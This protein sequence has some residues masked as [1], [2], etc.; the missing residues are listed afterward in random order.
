MEENLKPAP[1]EPL[2]LK[3]VNSYWLTAAILAVLLV[4]ASTVGSSWPRLSIEL[5]EQVSLA[6]YGASIAGSYLSWIGIAIA[7]NYYHRKL[8]MFCRYQPFWWLIHGLLS[9]SIGAL[10]LLWDTYLLWIALGQNFSLQLAY[11]EKILRWLPFEILA[12]WACLGLFTAISTQRFFFN[13]TN[14]QSQYLS[15]LSIRI[16]GKLELLEVA[17]IEWIESCDN[18]VIVWRNNESF[19]FKNTMNNLESK[20]D[21]SLFLRLHRSFIVNISEIK[22]VQKTEN[23]NNFVE[24]KNGK[25]LPVSRRRQSNINQALKSVS[26]S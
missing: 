13:S 6:A 2:T 15:R 23:G 16:R 11:I 5:G 8:P 24:L 17:E 21:P 25:R 7:I 1:L 19:M 12:Y 4:T 20:L 3:L 26:T 9:I 14:K 22:K 18:Y 10:H